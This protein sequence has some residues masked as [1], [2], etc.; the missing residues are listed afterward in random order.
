MTDFEKMSALKTLSGEKDE[1]ILL[2]Y[3]DIAKTKIMQKAFPFDSGAK[4]MPDKYSANQI[5]IALYLL[6]KRGAEGEVSHSE[7]GISRTYE[8]AD[9]PARMLSGIIP[10]GKIVGV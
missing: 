8:N 9:V 10:R 6:N 7:N 1:T 2:A 4:D 3:L 5:E